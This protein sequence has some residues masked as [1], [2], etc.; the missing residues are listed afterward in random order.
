MTWIDIGCLN[1][2][3]AGFILMIA[4]LWPGILA[5]D[6]Y[7]YGLI[8]ALFLIRPLSTLFSRAQPSAE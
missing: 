2:A 3:V 6:W 5:L 4:K 1:W 7:W 8:G